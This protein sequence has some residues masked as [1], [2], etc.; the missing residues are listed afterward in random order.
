LFSE[1]VK[2]GGELQI[3]NQQGA[4]IKTIELNAND[5]Y[6]RIETD[7]LPQGIYFIKCRANGTEATQ[8]LIIMN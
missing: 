3:F 1:P 5:R 7:Q 2:S 4:L 8:K 6:L